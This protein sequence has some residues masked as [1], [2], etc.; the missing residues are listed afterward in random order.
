MKT[1]T[2]EELLNWAF[3]HELPK[4]GGTDGLANANSAWRMLQASSWGKVM[5]FAELMAMVDVDF[6][7]TGNFWIDQGEPHDDALAVGNA[8]AALAHCDVEFPAEWNVL[9]DWPGHGGMTAAAVSRV[10]DRYRLRPPMRRAAGIVSLVVGTAILGRQPDWQAPEPKLR[11]V[12][13]GGKPAW[14]VMRS[15]IDP[16]SGLAHDL[17]IDGFNRRT[18]RP[19]RGAYRKWEFSADPSGDILSRL[20]W[21]IWVAALRR[22]EAAVA[23]RLAAHRLLSWAQS[24][25]PWLMCDRGGVDLVEWVTKPVAKKTSAGR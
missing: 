7:G 1:V 22:I 18:Q 9:S 17:E 11:L 6:G 19:A 21:Q 4:G 12:E 25:T 3:V 13:R 15:V 16:S 20:D 2:I 24:A 23:G 5:A 8:V 14:F 10:V